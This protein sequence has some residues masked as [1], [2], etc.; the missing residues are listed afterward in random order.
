MV[1]VLHFSCEAKKANLANGSLFSLVP[2]G[3]FAKTIGS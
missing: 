1:E 2:V 3:L